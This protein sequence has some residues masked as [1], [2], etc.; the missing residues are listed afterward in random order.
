[1]LHTKKTE[2][3][4]R[5]AKE[6]VIDPVFGGR[7]LMRPAPKFKLPKEEMPPRNAYQLVHDE[8]M[9]DGHARLNLATFVT[10]WIEPEARQLMSE[11]FDKN[12]IDK[13]HLVP[14]IKTKFFGDMKIRKER[15]SNCICLFIIPVVLLVLLYVVF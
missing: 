5:R 8:L 4:I 11:S 12:M 10:T 13:R 6:E 1:M 9:L 7:D 3:E 2:K 14:Y 15:F